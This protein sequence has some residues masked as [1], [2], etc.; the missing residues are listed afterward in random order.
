MRG[1]RKTKEMRDIKLDKWSYKDGGGVTQGEL[2]MGGMI[3]AENFSHTHNRVGS[4]L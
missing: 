3:V 2:T 1:E 4:P